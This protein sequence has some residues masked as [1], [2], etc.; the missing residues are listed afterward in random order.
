MSLIGPSTRG[1]GGGGPGKG[2]ARRAD[3]NRVYGN[4][5]P[6]L[7]VEPEPPRRILERLTPGG[8]LHSLGL[9]P[10]E[11]INPHCEGVFDP[12]TKSVWVTDMRS[13][14]ILWQRGFFGKGHLSRSEPSWLARQV[15]DRRAA[16]QG[17]KC[18]HPHL[19]SHNFLLTTI[20]IDLCSISFFLSLSIV[21]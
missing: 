15:N 3:N 6:F 10:T 19:P 4:P 8:I 7:F 17:S 21:S 20:V 5:L 2:G 12:A 13:V 16:A 1:R 18:L 14:L 9:R 11:V